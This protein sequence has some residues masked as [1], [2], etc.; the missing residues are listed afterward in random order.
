MHTTDHSFRVM[1]VIDVRENMKAQQQK[2]QQE[3]SYGF[4]VGEEKAAN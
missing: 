4:L 2:G 3:K 1:N